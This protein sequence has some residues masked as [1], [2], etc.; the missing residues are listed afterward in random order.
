[1]YS[2]EQALAALETVWSNYV[3]D[4][5][6]GWRIHRLYQKTNKNDR[7]WRCHLTQETNVDGGMGYH[8]ELVKGMALTKNAAFLAAVKQT[9]R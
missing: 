3:P 5:P 4:P 2:I 1:M 6:E 8:T 9:D 7:R